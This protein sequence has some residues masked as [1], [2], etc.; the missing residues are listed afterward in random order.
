MKKEAQIKNEIIT[1][2]LDSKWM[3][4]YVNKLNKKFSKYS[5]GE[6]NPSRDSLISNLWESLEIYSRNNDINASYQAIE[7]YVFQ[8]A[9]TL[10]SDEFVSELG[11]FRHGK[12]RQWKQAEVVYDEVKANQIASYD[13]YPSIDGEYVYT[14][15]DKVNKAYACDILDENFTRSQAVFGKSVLT[16]GAEVTV[17]NFELNKKSF[18]NR[19][20][21]TIKAIEKKRDNYIDSV[22]TEEEKLIS[23]RL[24][25][26]NRVVKYVENE[27]SNE[28]FLFQLLVDVWG[29]SISYLYFEAFS[30]HDRE[31]A[32]QAFKE[33]RGRKWA[34][35]LLNCLYEEKDKLEMELKVA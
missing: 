15:N 8:K 26:I 16:L 6:S 12:K 14:G 20:N 5:T 3:D 25:L 21:R 32:L 19:L 29:G 34:Y 9:Y 30:D 17:A 18:N 4:I 2:L 35:Q 1:K 13:E 27:K 33:K 11:K 10:T 31:L 22:V 28:V 23:D 7:R 24:S